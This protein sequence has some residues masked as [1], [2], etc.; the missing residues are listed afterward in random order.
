MPFFSDFKRFDKLE[1]ISIII[2][3]VGFLSTLFIYIFFSFRLFYL[4]DDF[5]LLVEAKKYGFENLFLPIGT[6]LRPIMRFHFIIASL[7]FY[8]P[9][10]NNLISVII[11]IILLYSF[12]L[13]LK[14]IYNRKIA[15]FSLFFFTIFSLYNEAIYWISANGVLYNFI[16]LN[17]SLYFYLK[18]KKFLSFLFITLSFFSYETWLLIFPLIFFVKISKKHKLRDFFTEPVI[19][20]SLLLIILQIIYNRIF[21]IKINSYGT[22]HSLSELP[23][24]LMIYFVRALSPLYTPDYSFFL[25]LMILA[26]I[27]AIIIMFLS[28]FNFKYTYPLTLYFGASTIFLLSAKIGSRFYLIPIAGLSIILSIVIVYLINLS[29]KGF[30]GVFIFLLLTYFVIIPPLSLYIDGI[31]YNGISNIYKTLILKNE[32]KF[33][34][35]KIGNR[36]L[37]E[38]RIDNKLLIKYFLNKIIKKRKL[39]YYREKSIGGFIY[40]NDFVDFILI[41]KGL[42]SKRISCVK[43]LRKKIKKISIG[44]ENKVYLTYCFIVKEL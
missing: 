29:K 24:R 16:F 4:F 11:F 38:I 25:V 39:I 40:P 19:F 18:E 34:S 27:G 44:E 20:F 3:S 41:K 31:D 36:L 32:N 7:F 12:F 23:Y 1:R 22:I 2:L 15:I 30:F 35:V 9:I 10:I 14:E 17:L 8:K 26:I 42:I 43:N 33:E 13:I 37:L 5:Q 28:N 6:H 21:H